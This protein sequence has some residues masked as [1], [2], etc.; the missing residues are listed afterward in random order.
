MV[1]VTHHPLLHR[2][3]HIIKTRLN[4]NIIAP[5][6]SQ[7]IIAVVILDVRLIKFR[8]SITQVGRALARQ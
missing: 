3:V 1:N 5:M 6:P 7:K 4:V 8:W 2:P